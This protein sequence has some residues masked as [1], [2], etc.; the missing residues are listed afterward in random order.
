VVQSSFY[1]KLNGIFKR[2]IEGIYMDDV[3]FKKIVEAA[4]RKN[5]RI[6]FV[7]VSKCSNLDLYLMFFVNFMIFNNSGPIFH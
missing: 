1:Y 2:L 3:K 7:P 4:K 5:G 6:V